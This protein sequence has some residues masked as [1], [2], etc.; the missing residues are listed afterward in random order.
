MP[1]AIFSFGDYLK[2]QFS[3]RV[4]KVTIDAELNCPNRDGS[5]ASGG[6][7]YCNNKSFNPNHVRD[8]PDIEGQIEAGKRIVSR[9]TG[10]QKVLAYF[11]AYSNTYA[12]LAHLKM[13]Y[14][15][16]LLHPG[17]VGLVIGTRPDCVSRDVLE[18]LVS[19]QQRGY[20]IWIEYGLQSV[21][22]STLMRINRGH[23]FAEYV[24]TVEMTRRLGLPVC[25]HLILGLP[26]E[27]RQMML[28]SLQCILDIGTDGLK[29]HPLHVVRHTKLAAQ[30]KKGEISVLSQPEYVSLVCDM[31]ERIPADCAIH[32]LTGTASNDV[33]LA[34][35]WCSAKWQVI[36]AIHQEMARRSSSQGCL[37]TQL[38]PTKTAC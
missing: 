12:P 15:R 3:Y 4:H 11:Q 18:L 37:H 14:E 29:F 28:Q 9:R 34:P 23:S 35:A 1:G 32:R 16:A 8:E 13:L 10:A 36:N 31:L 6:C 17:V 33:L 2:Q 30:W 27:D 5:K 20:E 26:G 7:T 24:E 22:D 38:I 21:H 25:T 19:Y